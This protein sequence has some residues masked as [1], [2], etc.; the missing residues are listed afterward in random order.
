MS[1]PIGNIKPFYIEENRILKYHLKLIYNTLKEI[2]DNDN[3]IKKGSKKMLE[4]EI[5]TIEKL[6]K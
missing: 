5:K 3:S 6:L 2:A 4:S 1:R